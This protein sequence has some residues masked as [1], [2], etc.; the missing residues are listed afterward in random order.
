MTVD[1]G[2]EYFSMNLVKVDLCYAKLYYK[3]QYNVWKYREGE[4]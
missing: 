3:T 4:R 1:S 2:E